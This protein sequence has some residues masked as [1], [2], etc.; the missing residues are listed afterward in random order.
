MSL[1]L[2]GYKLAL[3]ALDREVKRDSVRAHLASRALE[4]LPYLPFLAPLT[5]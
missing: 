4:N 3:Q 1:H 5:G 2:V